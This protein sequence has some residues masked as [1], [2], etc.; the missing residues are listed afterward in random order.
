MH[1]WK[2]APGERIHKFDHGH[3]V[4]IVD[5]RECLSCMK[6]L[7]IADFMTCLN[8]KLRG[9]GRKNYREKNAP[10]KYF[11]RTPSTPFSENYG[12]ASDLAM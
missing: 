4:L 11:K 8:G 7:F 5:M 6:I 1:F 3:D 10:L 9:S 2:T 12:K